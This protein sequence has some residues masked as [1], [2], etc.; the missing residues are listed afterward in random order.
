LTTKTTFS[1]FSARSFA[2]HSTNIHV[3]SSV[4]TTCPRSSRLKSLP[5]QT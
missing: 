1:T 5:Q 4:T 2:Y 3:T